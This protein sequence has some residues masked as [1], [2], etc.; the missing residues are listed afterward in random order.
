MLKLYNNGS[1]PKIGKGTMRLRPPTIA[2]LPDT[3]SCASQDG[4]V[5]HGSRRR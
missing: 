5:A 3:G 1:D 4:G 2:W